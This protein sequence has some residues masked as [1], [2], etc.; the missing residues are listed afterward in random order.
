MQ[1]LADPQSLFAKASSSDLKGKS[2]LVL[3]RPNWLVLIRPPTTVF[4]SIARVIAL[5][6]AN[7]Q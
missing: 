3:I 6:A 5:P 7:E 1:I 2:W 4:P